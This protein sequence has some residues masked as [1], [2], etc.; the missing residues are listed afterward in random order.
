MIEVSPALEEVPGLAGRRLSCR[1]R[2][3]IRGLCIR[4]L[5]IRRLPIRRLRRRRLLTRG[6][7]ARTSSILRQSCASNR[8][9]S[10]AKRARKQQYSRNCQE[11]SGI[12]RVVH[13]TGIIEKRSSGNDHRE[14]ITAKLASYFA[15]SSGT[16]PRS[17]SIGSTGGSPPYHAAYILPRSSVLPRDSTICR[18]RSPLARVIPP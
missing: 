15:P 10:A 18:K 14:T 11:R 5:R 2:R 17:L 1:C 6:L 7:H 13:R 3:R 9:L 12:P 4:R 16:N 8:H